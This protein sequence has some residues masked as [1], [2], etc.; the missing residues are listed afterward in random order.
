MEGHLEQEDA[1]EHEV[2]DNNDGSDDEN[3]VAKDL[4]LDLVCDAV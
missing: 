4:P 3:T 2:E 1:H